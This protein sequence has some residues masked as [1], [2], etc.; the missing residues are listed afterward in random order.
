M[1]KF[2]WSVPAPMQAFMDV[3]QHMDDHGINTPLAEIVGQ[4]LYAWIAADQAARAAEPK[5]PL[6]GYQ[7]K[8]LFLPTGSVLRT[9]V[10][11]QQFVARVDGDSLISDGQ[12]TTPSRFANTMH[13]YCCNAWT[14]I[15]LLFPNATEWVRADSVRPSNLCRNK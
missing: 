15:W 4:A 13:G 12:S 2:I 1:D 3:S 6:H 14:S 5:E 11:K 7:W 8:S 10:R 9:V